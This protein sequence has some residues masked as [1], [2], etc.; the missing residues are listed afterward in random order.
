MAAVLVP[1]VALAGAPIA[2]LFASTTSAIANVADIA[3]TTAT[4]PAPT[5]HAV[6]LIGD[7][8]LGVL[9]IGSEGP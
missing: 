1:T 8:W 4:S 6:D 5:D 2:S 7:H 3:G 9:P